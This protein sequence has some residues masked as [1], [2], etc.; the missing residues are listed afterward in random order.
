LILNIVEPKEWNG[1]KHSVLPREGLH[2]ILYVDVFVDG[3]EVLT[4]PPQVVDEKSV[5]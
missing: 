1:K 3:L 2:L 5:Q 4:L